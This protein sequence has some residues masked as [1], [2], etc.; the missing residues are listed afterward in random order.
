MKNNFIKKIIGA[1]LAFAM[2]IGGAVGIFS[3][4]EA[5]MVDATIDTANGYSA[6]TMTAGTNGSTAVVTVGGNDNDAIKVGSS[7]KGGDLSITIPSGATNLRFYAAAW[8]GVTGLS[9]NISKTSGPEGASISAASVNLTADDGMTSNSPFTLSGNES[10]FCFNLTLSG[11]TSEAVYKFTTSTTKRFVMWSAQTKTD[12]NPPPVEDSVSVSIDPTALNL[13]LY[14]AASGSLTAT[15]T[16]TGDA[17]LGLS[18]ISDNES[19]ATVST[20]TPVSG[21]AFTVTAHATGTA[22]ITVKS[23]W[24]ENETAT[25][26]VTVVNTTPRIVNF[27]KANALSAGLRVLITSVVDN[28]YYYMP[29]TTTGSS[30]PPLA[31]TCSYNST[32]ERIENINANLTFVVGGN[33]DGWTFTNSEGKYLYNTNTNNGVRIGG[34]G[35]AYAFTVA[36][37]E[38]GYSMQ[39]STNPRYIGIYNKTDW[40]CYTTI[41]ASNY[42][43]SAPNADEYNSKYINFWVEA[44][45]DQTITGATS[46]Y[47]DETVELTSN[48]TNPTWS[49]VAGDTT[50]EGAQVTAAGVVSATSAGIVKVKAS[51]ADYEDAFHTITFS[52]RPTESYIN[53][54]SATTGF[55]GQNETLEFDFGNIENPATSISVSS[56]NTSIVTV[57]AP[58]IGNGAGTV[59]INFVGAG[60]ANVV[61][62]DGE[63]EKASVAVTV[64]QSSVAITGMPATGNVFIGNTL[65]LADSITV[66][67]TGSYSEN[68]TWESD[69]TNV[70]TV[71][72]GI[73]TGVAEGTANITVT[74]VSD[75]NVSA[76]C[77]VTV[78]RVLFRS[79]NS[80][81]NG[82]RYILAASAS[83]PANN[84]KTYYL[85]AASETIEK[86]PASEELISINQLTKADAW[87]ASVDA[88]GHIVFSNTVNENTYYLA[89]TNTAQGISV[90]DTASS[91]YW[92]LDEKGLTYSDSGSRYLA[93]YQ[94][95]SFRYYGAPA[96]TGQ[97]IANVFYEYI[98]AAKEQVEEA[99]TLSALTY[100]YQQEGETYTFDNVAMRFG[101]FLSQSLYNE[102]GVVEFGVFLTESEG[103]HNSIKEDY[104][105]ALELANDD[106]SA[107]LT[108]LCGEHNG[109]E[110][111]RRFYGTNPV[112]AN[113]QQKAFMGADAEQTYYTWTI[114]KNVTNALTTFYTAVAYVR[115][116]TEIIFLDEV[117]ESA[118]NLATTSL[119]RTNPS[120]PAYESLEYFVA[121]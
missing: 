79:V 1:T 5:K 13:D 9:L 73:V 25:C 52:V 83:M 54:K 4:Q 120:D 111:I 114:R 66:T 72:N 91:G 36:S 26:T 49:I 16:K 97:S 100:E 59:Q 88:S 56:S 18:A 34:T 51:H 63:D 102:L 92:T 20:A 75:N 112:E 70:A 95:S 27:K 11:I 38:H 118:K 96:Q 82:R 116:A 110:S 76:T 14:N 78:S 62:K 80:F 119:A 35:D 7:S 89:A 10:D 19:V 101:G 8:K 47:T 55:T 57:N 31:T 85:P 12:D 115:T 121:H 64:T 6:A 30:N 103:R 109:D 48:A 90:V 61:F 41:D 45:P 99:K 22:H 29:S 39:G 21:T 105:V 107:A 23:T 104:E 93:T 32:T 2:M 24:D 86:N 77:A 65:N 28:E 53:V 33:S 67:A 117:S 84:G 46:A 108:I 68:V 113:E 58:S 81:Q 3:A 40:R 43:W 60:N 37:T 69:A 87:L 71:E 50:A 106:I 94:D 42:A 44:K 15:A 98:P 74:S 17:T